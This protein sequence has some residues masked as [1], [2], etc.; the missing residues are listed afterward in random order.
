MSGL[1]ETRRGNINFVPVLTKLSVESAAAGSFLAKR[2]LS[3]YI[4]QQMP[5]KKFYSLNPAISNIG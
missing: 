2:F 4:G 5:I 3:F 1:Y